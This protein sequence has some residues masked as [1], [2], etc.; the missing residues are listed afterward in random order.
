MGSCLGDLQNKFCLIYINDIVIYSKDADEH[1]Q[2]LETVFSRLRAA[3]LKLKPSK[4]E[5]YHAELE[6]LGHVISSDGVRTNPK[7]VEAV[8]S[9]PCPSTVT[10]LQSFLGFTG[11]YHRFIRHYSAL[12]NPLNQHLRGLDGQKKTTLLQWNDASE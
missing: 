5:F 12:A 4:C 1:F 7:K 9:W 10:E 8:K 6:Y 2:H 3:G 11:Y